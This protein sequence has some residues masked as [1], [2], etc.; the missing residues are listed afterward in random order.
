MN[1]RF[2]EPDILVIL[3][4]L[5]PL[6]SSLL[7]LFSKI[8]TRRLFIIPSFFVWFFGTV[9]VLF[10]SSSEILSGGRITHALGGWQEPYGIVLELH[11]I[12]WIA[13]L[14]LLVIGTAVFFHTV[15]ENTYGPFFYVVL[16][17]SLFSLQGI[18]CT[19]DMFNLFV[20]FEILSLC[21]LVLIAYDQTPQALLAAFR[22]LLMCTI[23]ILFFLIGV[24]VL[25]R[26][27]GTLS[28]LH[29]IRSPHSCRVFLSTLQSSPCGGFSSMWRYPIFRILSSGPVS[30]RL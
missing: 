26:Y 28:L 17:L 25:Y 23:S 19:R 2:T 21:S 12:T 30:S 14:L 7:C 18:L 29:P 5:L 22:Y 3:L 10:A 27:T 4:L 8:L 11:G 20:F 9:Y 24:W 1:G 15:R 6:L 13:D 16:F